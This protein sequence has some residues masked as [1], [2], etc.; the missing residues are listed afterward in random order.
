MVKY[1][2]GRRQ[3]VVVLSNMSG[4]FEGNFAV[5]TGNYLLGLP[6]VDISL[7]NESLMRFVG[8]TVAALFFAV[9]GVLAINR[10]WK[11]SVRS[12]GPA[13]RYRP[14]WSVA[15]SL[16]LLALAYGLAVVVPEQSGVN[17]AAIRTFYPDIGLM[18]TIAAVSAALWAVALQLLR[19]RRGPAS[20][21]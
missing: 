14:L 21:E 15:T 2:P 13:S 1:L 6:D 9:G 19:S 12:S 8:A 20:V 18:I 10:L 4:S 17:L 3:G 16:I 5:G 11:K 7:P